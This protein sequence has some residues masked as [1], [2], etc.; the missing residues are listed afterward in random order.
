[1][2]KKILQSFAMF[3][4]RLPA[5]TVGGRDLPEVVMPRGKYSTQETAKGRRPVV[6]LDELQVARVEADEISM[7]GFSPVGNKGKI[8]YRW[9]DHMPAQ[10]KTPGDE[11]VRLQ[12][13]NAVLR[14]ELRKHGVAVPGEPVVAA[15]ADEVG[16]DRR[17]DGEVPLGD[18]I[19]IPGAEELASTD[20]SI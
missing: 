18:A 12:Q 8:S 4:S 5:I 2:G 19:R 10:Y 1:M 15:P 13:E 6:E 3:E 14:N 11:V 20:V 7:R 17:A 9:L 16:S